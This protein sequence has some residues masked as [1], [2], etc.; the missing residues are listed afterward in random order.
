ML[1]AIFKKNEDMKY[2][3]GIAIFFTLLSCSKAEFPDEIQSKLTEQHFRIKGTKL[4]VKNIDG[5]TY[6]PDVNVFKMSDSVYIHCLYTSGDFQYEYDKRKFDFFHNKNYKIISNKTFSINGL[7]GIYYRLVE[8]NSYWL[9]FIFGDS[10]IENRIVATFPTNNNFEKKIYDFVE[11]IFYQ[12]NY[13]LDELEN[14]KF[15]VDL[16]KSNYKFNSFSMNSFVFTQN[17]ED[18]NDRA[19]SIYISQTPP[20]NTSSALKSTLLTIIENQKKNMN[21]TKI[22]IDSTLIDS[23]KLC[24]TISGTFENKDFYNKV[25]VT[26]NAKTGL[27]FGFAL[28]N[29]IGKN[30]IMTDSIINTIT[31]K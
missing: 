2:L 8:G 7:N 23:M 31:I 24:A 28:Y 22:N 1:G 10:N 13:Q 16:L 17:P 18:L 14:A 9:Y 11:S 21:I 6:I 5:F 25:I 20:I 19:N 4:F 30:I 12:P 27:I 29:N 26:S 15:Q 3:L